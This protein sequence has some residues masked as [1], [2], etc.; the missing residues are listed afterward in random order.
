M[1]ELMVDSDHYGPGR[2]NQL[3]YRLSDDE[4]REPPGPES[5]SG[6][7]ASLQCP[8]LPQ[9]IAT[10]TGSV[11][12]RGTLRPLQPP[13]MQSSLLSELHNLH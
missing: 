12:T 13:K 2:L 4:I 5:H 10:D 9:A 7:I 3:S 1:S 8:A 11:A 6:C